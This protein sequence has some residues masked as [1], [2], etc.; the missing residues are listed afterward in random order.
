ME[1]RLFEIL[2]E[3]S[4]RIVLCPARSLDRLRIFTSWKRAIDS[5]R[6][7]VASSLPSSIRSN[8]A[9]SSSQRNQLVAELASQIIIT[10]ASEDSR[11]ELFALG[12]LQS[13][14]EVHCLNTGCKRLLASGAKVIDTD[15]AAGRIL[16]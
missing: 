3:G 13:G 8:S 14:M 2:L 5:G 6:L 9:G 4:C 1:K 11:T 16:E 15:S 7:V 12:L 10:Y